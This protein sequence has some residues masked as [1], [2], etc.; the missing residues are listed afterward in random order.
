MSTT[1]YD[2]SVFKSEARTL[3]ATDWALLFARLALGAIFFAHGSQ[4]VL[5]WFGGPGI[6]A[7][8]AGM[9]KLGLPAVIAY[10]TM[11]VEFL[12]GLGLI[13][14]VLSRLASLGIIAVMLGAIFTV[15]LPNGLFMNW[16]GNQKGEGFEY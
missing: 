9:T 8:V 15:H 16:M 4:K 2:G 13:F 12:G 14:G 6:H 7:T 3:T 1:T 10:F 11:T 5:G